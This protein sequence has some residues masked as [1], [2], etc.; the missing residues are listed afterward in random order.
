VILSTAEAEYIVVGSSCAQ[1]LWLKQ[2]LEDFR[3]K[4]SKVPLLCDN[5]SVIN[6]TKNQIQ[7]SRTK[8]IEICH[9]F[10]RDHVNNGDSEVKFIETG[11]QLAYIFTKPLPKDRFFFLRNELGILDSQTLS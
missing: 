5:T 10:I 9:H 6:L 4:V 2:Q 3:L 1:I 7:H 11:M 8:Q